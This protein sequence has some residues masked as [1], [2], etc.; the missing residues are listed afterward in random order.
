MGDPASVGR[1]RASLL[2]SQS[3]ARWLT[4][5]EVGVPVH[6]VDAVVALV[7][8]LDRR[9]AGLSS[10]WGAGGVGVLAGRAASIGLGP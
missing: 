10:A 2:W 9:G 4:D 7:G 8:R 3:G 1:E 6:V 5:S